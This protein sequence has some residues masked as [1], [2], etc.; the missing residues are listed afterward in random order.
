V[1]ATCIDGPLP[2]RSVMTF[3]N[4]RD[5]STT[6]RRRRSLVRDQHRPIRTICLSAVSGRIELPVA[7]GQQLT[8]ARSSVGRAPPS[9]GGG[10]E[11]ESRRV[12]F[13]FPSICRG[14]GRSESRASNI[15]MPLCSNRAATRRWSRARTMEHSS[16]QGP[17]LLLRKPNGRHWT[18]IP[19]ASISI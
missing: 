2:E 17:R 13:L 16:P 5:C 8:R 6:L 12:H 15:P 7:E 11:F 4:R 18:R 14:N 19:N 1:A 10:H 3:A 9:H